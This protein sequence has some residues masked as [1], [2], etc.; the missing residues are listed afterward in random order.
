MVQ[1]QSAHERVVAVK[2]AFQRP[3]QVGNF[4]PHLAFGQLGEHQ[5]AALAIDECFHHRPHRPGGDRRGH[6]VDLDPRV[7]KDVAEPLQLTGTGLGELGAVTDDIA[8]GFDL[9]RRD[10]RTPQQSAFEQ[11]NQPFRI[12]QVFSELE[13]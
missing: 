4:R 5:W 1:M 12:G 2:A 6:R 10:E 7:L 8:C 3:L 13:K 9:R 11:V